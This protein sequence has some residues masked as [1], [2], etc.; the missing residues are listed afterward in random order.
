MRRTHACL[1]QL[2]HWMLV[3]AAGFFP[4]VCSV[5]SGSRVCCSRRVLSNGARPL[6]SHND[7]RPNRGFKTNRHRL[8]I[9]GYTM[10]GMPSGVAINRHRQWARHGRNALMAFGRLHWS[11]GHN[12][13][14]RRCHQ[15]WSRAYNRRRRCLRHSWNSAPYCVSSRS[16]ESDGYGPK[17]HH[18]TSV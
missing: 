2:I 5:S 14:A 12:H 10:G 17:Q 11:R 4:P 9:A 16:S 7:W 3:Q 8:L 1:E 18:D 13:C 15:C 6:S